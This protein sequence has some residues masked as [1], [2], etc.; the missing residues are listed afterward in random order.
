MAGLVGFGLFATTNSARSQVI[1]YGMTA[2]VPGGGAQPTNR[3]VHVDT[4][5]G[6]VSNSQDIGITLMVGISTQPSTGFLYGLS[7]DFSNVPNTLMRIDSGTGAVTIVGPTGLH[8]I[9]GDLAFNPVN[10]FLYGIQD[11]GPNGTQNNLF[12]INPTT[13]ASFV[14]GNT[15][16]PGDLS[17]LAFSP[18]GVLYTIDSAG[19]SNSLLQTIDPSTGAI[20]NTVAMNVNL[21]SAVGMAFNPITGVAYVGDNSPSP[22]SGGTNSV[23]TLNVATGDLTLIGPTNDPNGLCGLAFVAIPEPSSTALTGLTLFLVGFARRRRKSRAV[24]TS[25]S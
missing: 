9:E 19:L 11:I 4:T 6:N 15:G 12:R 16:S 8:I 20:L 13:G 17:A 21:G 22:A 18:S 10:G 5:T 7:S 25:N 3:L 2:G 23:Y 24:F 1:L 14:V